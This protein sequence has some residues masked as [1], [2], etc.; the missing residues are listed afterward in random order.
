MGNTLQILTDRELD[1]VTGGSTHIKIIGLSNIEFAAN[2]VNK[3]ST[4]KGGSVDQSISSTGLSVTYVS[5]GF[6]A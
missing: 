4:S 1:E 5:L 2:V 3:S 6:I